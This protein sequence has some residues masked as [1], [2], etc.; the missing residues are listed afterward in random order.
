MYLSCNPP[1]KRPPSPYI[2]QYRPLYDSSISLLQFWIKPLST[3]SDAV[4]TRWNFRGDVIISIDKVKANIV[5]RLCSVCIG[6]VH[7]NMDIAY[8]S[9]RCLS[10]VCKNHQHRSSLS[11]FH[12]LIDGFGTIVP[13]GKA[14]DVGAEGFRN[15]W[16]DFKKTWSGSCLNLP[17]FS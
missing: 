8:N 17:P 12:Q 4:R 9:N 10:D 7:V 2:Y 14:S 1:P 11:K 3:V 15:V 16:V 5:L 6:S 13:L